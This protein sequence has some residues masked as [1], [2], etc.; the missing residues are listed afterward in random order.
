[1]MKR[2]LRLILGD[3]L[4]ASHS[5]FAE[6]SEHVTYL[7]A[8]LKQEATYTQHHVQKVCAFFAAMSSFAKALESAGHQVIYLT[9]DDTSH[10]DD[11]ESLVRDLVKTHC[12]D[13]FSYQLPDEFRLREQLANFSTRLDISVNAV[14][15]EHFYLADA[16]LND[17]FKQGKTHR[18]E[19]FYRKLR[20]QFDILMED[21]N[22]LGG[23]WNYDSKNRNKLK[24]ADLAEI[25]EPCSLVMM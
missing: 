8:E 14:E 19:H 12:F 1:M 21:G 20:V 11:L 13:S 17:Y 2:E 22:P 23:E 25:P 7:I 10:F 24:A 5:W 6:K 18:L 4:N 9:L 3:Q 16:Q 15:S